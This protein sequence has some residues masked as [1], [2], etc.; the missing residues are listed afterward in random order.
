MRL[1]VSLLTAVCFITAAQ[2]N[3]NGVATPQSQAAPK[4]NTID[5]IRH[6]RRFVRNWQATARPRVSGSAVS[7]S[8]TLIASNVIVFR[9]PFSL[10]QQAAPSLGNLG[11][12][13]LFPGVLVFGLDCA[14]LRRSP[15]RLTA[16]G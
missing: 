10:R 15:Y 8:A 5:M 12:G 11:R 7:S 9:L 2:A 6:R 4:P 13:F 14:M 1:V 3:A 16:P